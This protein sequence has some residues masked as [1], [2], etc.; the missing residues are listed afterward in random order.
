M[1]RGRARV[2]LW[3]VSRY[4]F[5]FRFRHKNPRQVPLGELSRMVVLFQE[6]DPRQRQWSTES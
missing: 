6:R 1:E 5:R 2:N 3:S 4:F